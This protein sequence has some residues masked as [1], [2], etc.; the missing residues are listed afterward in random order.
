[1]LSLNAPSKHVLPEVL[2]FASSATGDASDQKKRHAAV[3]VLG[4]VAEGCAEGLADSLAAITPAIINALTD[5][6][7]DVRS[8]AAFTLGQLAEWVDGATAFHATALPAVFA[9]L[10]MERDPRVL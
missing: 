5:T 4:I 8:A 7:S 6:S 1:M 2:A 3:A 10:K 9:A